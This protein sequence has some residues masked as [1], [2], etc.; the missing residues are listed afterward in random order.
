MVVLQSDEFL[1]CELFLDVLQ[2][3]GNVVDV[4]KGLCTVA[5]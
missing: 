5:G 4:D 1:G 2:E 3:V